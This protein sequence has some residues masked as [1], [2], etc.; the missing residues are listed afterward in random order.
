MWRPFLA[1]LGACS[2]SPGGG[3]IDAPPSSDS[4][5]AS[6]A[7][8]I[9][10]KITDG[11]QI[12]AAA[13]CDGYTVANG[14]YYRLYT[15]P[16]SWTAAE[17]ACEADGY[18]RHLAVMPTAAEALTIDAITT[19]SRT[20]VGIGNRN[21]GQAW[22]WVDGSAGPVLDGQSDQCGRWY[23]APPGGGGDALQSDSC[24]E[25]RPYVCECDLIPP[26]PS[27]SD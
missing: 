27:S 17:A 7:V 12:D 4:S 14:S 13:T 5:A 2:F 16:L 24:G 18:G 19:A 26:D 20:W 21:D 22:K 6:D 15:A 8:L 3:S 25:T 1:L 23:D 9:D 10:A 11:G